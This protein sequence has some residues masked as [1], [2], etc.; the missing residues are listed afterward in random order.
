MARRSD[1]L[2]DR[3]SRVQTRP[4]VY[5]SQVPHPQWAFSASLSISTPGLDRPGLKKNVARHSTQ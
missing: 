5:L 3:K 1:G 4:K 2:W